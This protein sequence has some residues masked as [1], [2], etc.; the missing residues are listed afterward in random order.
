MDAYDWSASEATDGTRFSWNILPSSR[1]DATRLVVPA[2]AMHTP[3]KRIEGM[4]VL[5]YEPIVCKQCQGI[6]NPY[7]HVDFHSKVWGCCLCHTRNHFPAAYSDINE[8]HLPAELFPNYTA[9]EYTMSQTAVSA[10]AFLFVVD[11]CQPETD[12]QGLRDGIS[13]ALT[14][15]PEGCLVGLITF[16]RLIYVHEL[17]FS[18]VAKQYV[19]QGTKEVKQDELEQLL[20]IGAIKQ[21]QRGHNQPHGVGRFLLPITECEFALNTALEDLKTSTYPTQQGFRPQR[22]TGAALSVAANLLSICC[23]SVGSRLMLFSG[24]AATIGPGLVVGEDYG[25]ESMRSH[26]DFEKGTAKHFKK[27]CAFYYKLGEKLVSKSHTLDIFAGSLDQTGVA[28]AKAA[29]EYS[30]GVIVLAETFNSPTFKTSFA[31]LLATDDHGHLKLASNAV[32][33]VKT[34]REVKLNGAIGP[35]ASLRRAGPSVAEVEIGVGGTTQWRMCALDENTTVAVFLEVVNNHNS[36]QGQQGRGLFVQF[37]THYQHSSGETRLRVTTVARRWA[38][39][40]NTAEISQ[41]FDQEAAAVV[42]ARYACFRA[43][44]EPV[45]DILRWLDRLLIRLCSRFGEYHKNDPTSFRLSAAFSIYPQFMYHL[46]RSQFLQVFNNSPDETAFFRLM[47]GRENVLASLIMIQPTLLSYSL[48]GPPVPVLLDVSSIGLDKILLLDTYFVIVVHHGQ[49]IAQWRKAGYHEDPQHAHLKDL[50]EAPLADAEGL[51]EE[52]FP[53]PKMVVCDQ[54]GSQARFLLAK[55][56]PS[57]TH[58]SQDQAGEVIFTDDVSL[59][60]FMEHLQK[61]AVSS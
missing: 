27:A 45:F 12:L 14:I 3:L 48:E 8:N 44:T 54:A 57:Q 17:G 37:L 52:R 40:G 49:T 23:P 26:Q 38:D 16:D 42:M 19:F 35:L 32:L 34:V 21:K 58:Q 1:I 24:G 7:C 4:P 55:L 15:L 56:N 47:L 11:L 51:L 46:R 50:L 31:K 28:E 2:A 6:L 29:V 5:P 33:E 9:V 25:S 30:G 18:D 22:A 39:A 53:L 60:V 20:G 36:T 10:P 59:Q 41:G 43:E 13:Q 61:L